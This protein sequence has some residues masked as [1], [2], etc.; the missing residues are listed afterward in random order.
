[1]VPSTLQTKAKK[2][3][4]DQ[5]KKDT[6]HASGLVL[7]LTVPQ[8]ISLAWDAQ[9]VTVRKGQKSIVK[10]FVFGDLT[11]AQHGDTLRITAPRNTRDTRRLG[12]TLE[13]HLRNLFVGVQEGFTYS[14]KICSGHFPMNAS[15][16]GQDFIVKNFLGESVPRKLKLIQGVSVKIAGDQVTVHADSKESAGQVAASIEKLTKIKGRD[17]RVFQDGI[18]IT[19]KHDKVM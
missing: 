18:Y 3:R 19:K 13:A 12:G 11:L 7:E 2:K 14:L 1:M 6:A 5:N 16:S 17:L 15:V 8:G 9:S 10:N 4:A